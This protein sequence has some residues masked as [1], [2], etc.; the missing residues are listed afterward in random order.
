MKGLKRLFGR[1]EAVLCAPMAGKTV[2]LA[3]V[4]DSA[5]AEGMLGKGVAIVPADGKVYAPCD[6]TVECMFPTGHAVSMRADSGA[7]ILIHVGLETVSLS[8]KPFLVH[9]K[10]GDKVRKGQMLIEADL[11]AIRAAGLQTITPV[12]VCNADEY[13]SFRTHAGKTVSCADVIIELVK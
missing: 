13:T 4:P 7:E 8:G 9:V 1:N 6:A 3:D 2:E 12:V 10:N 5:F 11:A